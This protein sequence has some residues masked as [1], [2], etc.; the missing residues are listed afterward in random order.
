[1]KIK[2]KIK[3]SNF[4]QLYENDGLEMIDFEDFMMALKSS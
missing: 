3:R 4:I 1:M 2:N